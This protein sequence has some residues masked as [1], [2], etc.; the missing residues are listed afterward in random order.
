M[1]RREFI[2]GLG[3]AAVWPVAARAQRPAVPVVGFLNSESLE[4]RRAMLAAFHRGLAE[5]G[6]VEGRNLAIEYRWAE[7][8]N[9]RLPVLAAEL[10]RRQVSVIATPNNS[11]ATFAAKAATQTIP[12]VFGVG[13]DPVASGLVP[14]LNRPGGNLTGVSLLNVEVAAK[15]VELLH[16]LVPTTTSIAFLVNLANP[17]LVEADTR[18]VQRAALSLGMRMV[19]LNAGTRNEIEA[20]FETIVQHRVGALVVNSDALFFTEKKILAELA[21]RHAVPAIY[22]YRE[23]A[24]V[25]GLM[26]YGTD[27]SDGYRIVGTYV[28]RILQGEKPA[29]LPVQQVTKIEMVVNLKT[30]KALG[31]TFPLT[32]L[33]RADE[34]IE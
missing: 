26:S 16:E 10:V 32:L 2:A 30:A 24:A 14:S 22:Q 28:G 17:T 13:A 9:D 19:V 31:L 34:V 1:K 12:I 15:R 5:T 18:E 6:Y 29:E 4:P 8:R 25:G 7:G 33:G 23:N 21:A 3:A 11:A 27:A 20:A